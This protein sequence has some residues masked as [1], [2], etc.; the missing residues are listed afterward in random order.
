[1]AKARE[2]RAKKPIVTMTQ[3]EQIRV[4][5]GKAIKEVRR[6]AVANNIKLAV[7]DKKSWAVPK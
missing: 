2:T 3:D 1:M 7:A 4:A 5:M 6:N